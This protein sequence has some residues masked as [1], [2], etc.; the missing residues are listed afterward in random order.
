M[1]RP[2]LP[3]LAALIF[4]LSG[5]SAPAQP[6][7]FEL[8]GEGWIATSEPE[9]GSDEAIIAQARRLL[10]EG[11]PGEARKL[12]KPWIKKHEVEGH[13]LMPA[14]LLTMGDAKIA[15]GEFFQSLYDFEALLVFYPE[16]PEFFDG[17]E[18]ELQIGK[19][20]ASG[21][22]QRR[23]LG[24]FN[25]GATRELVEELLTLVP[26]RAPGSDVA[27]RAHLALA[28]YYYERRDL[29]FAA[30]AYELFAQN[31]PRSRHRAYA[32]QRQI[33]ANL[34]RFKGPRY[35]ASVLLEADNLITVFRRDFPM[36]AQEAG[37]SDALQA[38]IDESLGAQMLETADWYF[39]RN[40][41]VSARFQLQRLVVK[42]P[43]TVAAERAE[44]ILTERGWE[45]PGK[46]KVPETVEA[47]PEGPAPVTPPAADAADA[48][49][50][51]G[52][53]S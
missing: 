36:Q 27:E 19:M 41:L 14:A 18:R 29:P 32:M 6:T 50:P 9:P 4:T 2:F 44:E 47:D 20:Y 24:I 51:Q 39:R 49:A 46:A 10:A 48:P 30:L 25:F 23:F 42:H 8:G 11:K 31:F 52:G 12:L 38:R 3:I 17:L 26:Q 13:P 7:E 22:R 37:L 34:A 53:G 40:D 28:D 1:S 45:H 21:K 5:R 35:D 33:L 43:R 15:Q 16:S